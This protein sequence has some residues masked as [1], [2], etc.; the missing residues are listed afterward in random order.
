M[1]PPYEHSYT[2]GGAAA[3][4][5]LLTAAMFGL[6]VSGTSTLGNVMVHSLAGAAGGAAGEAIYSGLGHSS[7]FTDRLERQAMVGG[8][9][10]IATGAAASQVQN[11]LLLSGMLGVGVGVG[12][13]AVSEM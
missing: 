9:V 13:W 8:V 1:A 3:A 11:A 2:L 5:A 12:S 7:K 6:P 10:G 4:G